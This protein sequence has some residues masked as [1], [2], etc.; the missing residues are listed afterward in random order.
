MTTNDNDLPLWDAVHTIVFDFD[1][2]FTDNNVYV[3]EEGIE[4]VKC[5]RSDGLGL[6]MLNKY[7]QNNDWFLTTFVLSTEANP[8]V[9]KRA[10]KL[11]LSCV[12]AVRHKAPYLTSYLEEK[13]LDRS[14]L[15]YLCNDLNDLPAMEVAGITVAPCDAHPLVRASAKMIIERKGGDSFVRTFIEM[16]LR[17]NQM[18]HQTLFSIL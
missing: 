17:V 1:G 7:A 9:Q 14:G 11:G 8:V 2:V 16:L 12:Q 13:H 5:S 3:T 10:D 18:S 4:Y 6:S 15:I